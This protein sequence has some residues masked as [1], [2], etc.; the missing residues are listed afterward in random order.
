[1]VQLIVFLGLFF[2]TFQVAEASNIFDL[3]E[4]TWDG[5][6]TS[7]EDDLPNWQPL[8][9]LTDIPNKTHHENILQYRFY[10]PRNL[11]NQPG[12]ALLLQKVRYQFEVFLSG[13]SIYKFGPLDPH[14][15]RKFYGLP[16][17]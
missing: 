2:S 1:M 11:P 16:V 3:R 14:N 4:L 7:S 5:A 9:S 10:L 12:F 13:T 15:A 17:H 8:T 6:W